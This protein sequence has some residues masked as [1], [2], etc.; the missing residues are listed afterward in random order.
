MSTNRL[1]QQCFNLHYSGDKVWLSDP[2]GTFDSTRLR[3]ITKLLLVA[4]G[5]GNFH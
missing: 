4:A 2:E 1:I 3:D 5:T